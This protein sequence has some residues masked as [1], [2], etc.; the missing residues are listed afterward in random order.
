MA[1]FTEMI[2]S[3]LHLDHK[4]QDLFRVTGFLKILYRKLTH[5]GRGV[6]QLGQEETQRPSIC[7]RGAANQ[8]T[9]MSGGVQSDVLDRVDSERTGLVEDF[10]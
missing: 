3:R 1:N 4:L 8:S 10:Q 2:H 9:E 6:V 7:A 5:F